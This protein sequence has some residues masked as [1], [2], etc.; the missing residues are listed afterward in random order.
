MEGII[1]KY[2]SP[3]GKCYIGQTIS[4]NKRRRKFLNLNEDYVGDKINNARKKYGPE[5]FKYEVL[6]TVSSD[7]VEELSNLLNT[8]GIY[9]IGLY[10]TFKNGYNMSI[11][12]DGTRGYK[13]TE[14]QRERHTQ[15]M[16]TNN[17]FKGKKH[18]KETKE[19]IGKAN[20][21]A[22]YQIN[23]D[24][25]EIIREFSSA[26][27]AGEFF[28]KPRANSEIIKVCRHYVSPKGRHYI[29]A[30]GYKWAYKDE[31][32]NSSTT[33]INVGNVPNEKT[34]NQE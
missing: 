21:K 24:T 33:S 16:L 29:T 4:E 19:A 11:G 5:N 28:G 12:G 20:S 15:R 31:I 32:D 1:Y 13:M 26:K 8:L 14:E 3:S 6:E 30:L 27:E 18:T 9:Y 17:P 7:S 10:D 2:T 22:V 23:K 25:G 34:P